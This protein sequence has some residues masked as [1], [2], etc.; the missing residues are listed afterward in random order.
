[1]TTGRGFTPAEGF[2]HQPNWLRNT[3]FDQ[4]VALL[5]MN[6]EWKRNATHHRD[7]LPFDVPSV[8]LEHPSLLASPKHFEIHDWS[9]GRESSDTAN[10]RRQFTGAMPP[11]R[12]ASLVHRF[13]PNDLLHKIRSD[14]YWTLDLPQSP[15]SCNCSPFPVLST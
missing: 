4:L 15:E 10:I 9:D 8:F 11:F 5:S 12:G 7:H 13:E 14:P 2:D 6:D 3:V 1:V